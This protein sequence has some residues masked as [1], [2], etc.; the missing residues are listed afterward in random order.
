MK[1]IQA[2]LKN[3]NRRA[4]NSVS[5][6]KELEK[7]EDMFWKKMHGRIYYDDYET[8]TIKEGYLEELVRFIKRLLSEEAFTDKEL[9]IIDWYL[10]E[11]GTPEGVDKEADKLREKVSKLLKRKK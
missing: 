3:Y 1:V 8:V 6:R 4:D 2:E 9:E 5:L 7:F 10:Q 11:Y